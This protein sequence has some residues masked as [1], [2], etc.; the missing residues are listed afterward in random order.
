VV[1]GALA[2]VAIASAEIDLVPLGDESTRGLVSET[3]VA[4]GDQS[5]CHRFSLAR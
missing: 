1:G 3:L 5:D 4:S 2:A